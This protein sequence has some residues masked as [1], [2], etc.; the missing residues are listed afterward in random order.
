MGFNRQAIYCLSKVSMHLSKEELH[1]I[2]RILWLASWKQVSRTANAKNSSYPD[3]VWLCS[4]RRSLVTGLL[5][6]IRRDKNDADAWFDRSLLYVELGETKK[7]MPSADVSPRQLSTVKRE[8]DWH[9]SATRKRQRYSMTE[10]LSK[11]PNL[12]GHILDANG[13]LPS[14]HYSTVESVMDYPR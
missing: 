12:L 8:N 14:K 7:V 1:I 9:S 10:I 11:L 5:Q 13:K 4:H 6:V 3:Y 2:Q